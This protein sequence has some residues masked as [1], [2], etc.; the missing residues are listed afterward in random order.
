MKHTVSRLVLAGL[1][2]LSASLMA[3]AQTDSTYGSTSLGVYPPNIGYGTGG[4][5]MMLTAS[6]SMS[7]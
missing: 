2:L 5:M 7:S 4:P 3:W 1:G 6:P